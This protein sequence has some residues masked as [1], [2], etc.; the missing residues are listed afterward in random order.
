M[1]FLPL[2][3]LAPLVSAQYFSAGW[4][5]G[6][7]V[8][9]TQDVPAPSYT[10]GAE[11]PQA[12][13]SPPQP[14][15]LSE[16]FSINTLLTLPPVASIFERFGINITERVALAKAN[17]WDERIPL[18]TDENYQDLI[19]NEPLTEQEEKERVWIAVV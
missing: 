16:L 3:A 18:I 11:Q 2:L 4:Q 7:P 12:P 14:K 8:Q 10:P 15:S 5:P 1:R 9:H 19:V 6:Q 17:L 13:S